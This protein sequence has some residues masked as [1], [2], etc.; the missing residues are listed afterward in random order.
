[1]ENKLNI[2]YRNVSDLIPYKKNPRKNDSAVE[3]VAESIKTVGFVNPIVIDKNNEI[4]AGHTRLKAA[5]KLRMK[6]VPTIFAE[7]MT[8]EQIKAYRLI[9]NK[10][11]EFAL[12]NND[13]LSIE[14]SEIESIDMSVFNFDFEFEEEELKKEKKN[15]SPYKYCHVLISIP[16]EKIEQVAEVIKYCESKGY[17]YEQSNN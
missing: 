7:N 3:V 1:M 2:E 5:K 4:I 12:W 16:V 9:D 13:L 15:L 14:L 8:E 10:T 11:S 17:E 6:Q